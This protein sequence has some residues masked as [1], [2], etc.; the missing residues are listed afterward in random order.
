MIRTYCKDHKKNYFATPNDKICI[1][2]VAEPNKR[3]CHY[4]HCVN[5]VSDEGITVID[6][7]D[8]WINHLNVNSLVATKN[9]YAMICTNCY[10]E[11]SKYVEH[12]KT[13][14]YISMGFNIYNV[15]C[16][17]CEKLPYWGYV[18]C[19]LIHEVQLTR[20]TATEM[21]LR[22][23]ACRNSSK[24]HIISKL[25]KQSN[26]I[27]NYQQNVNLKH[28][29][30]SLKYE[31]NNLKKIIMI[32]AKKSPKIWKE[33]KSLL[34]SKEDEQKERKH[35]LINNIKNEMKV[36]VMKEEY[37]KIVTLN[38]ILKMNLNNLEIEL[39][40]EFSYLLEIEGTTTTT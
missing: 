19:L 4:K 33:V 31:V 14:K 16:E 22:T 17:Y 40:K 32:L 20:A 2:H 38:K 27:E 25:F 11:V 24:T 21:I 29:V 36:L 15:N 7:G 30:T 9:D 37:D 10:C 18:H 35:I 6:S 39:K 23:I 3:S 12:N 5:Q 13:I 34:M 1:T 28:E 8:N 26:I